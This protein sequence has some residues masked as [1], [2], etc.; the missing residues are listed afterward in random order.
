MGL[1]GKT[2]T[3]LEMIKFEHS[4]FALPFAL[5]GALLAVRG[6]GLDGRELAVKFAWI[7]VAMIAARSAAM[8]FNRVAD[9]EIDA[10]NPRSRMRAIPA[11]A[12]SKSFTWGFIAFWSGVFVLAAYLLNPLCLKLSPLALAIV[13]GYSY[14]KRFTALSHLALG[15]P[16]ASRRP[17]PGS[18]CA[19]RSTRRSSC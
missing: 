14:T 17:R 13:F 19:A 18:R 7:I 1:I 11:G 10:L 4:V 8:A 6:S 16:S 15:L 12:V 5:T 3:V 9:A 2:R